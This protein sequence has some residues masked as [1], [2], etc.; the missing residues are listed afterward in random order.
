MAHFFQ[1][2]TIHNEN[3]FIK[4]IRTTSCYWGQK[5]GSLN[6]FSWAEQLHDRKDGWRKQSM[7]WGLCA[8]YYYFYIN[9]V[10]V[11]LGEGGEENTMFWVMM[12]RC[13]SFW[14]RMRSELMAVFCWMDNTEYSSTSPFGP[15]NTCGNVNFFQFR[16]HF[17]W[18][19][20]NSPLNNFSFFLFSQQP[21]IFGYKHTNYSKNCIW[22][23][24]PCSSQRG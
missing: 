2:K 9:D 20:E 14:S 10:C 15:R 19:P 5:Q 7:K 23:C 12:K 11:C 6:Y 17:K 13:S 16:T 24:Y 8:H 3:I 22:P 18:E 1:R 4:I 21:C